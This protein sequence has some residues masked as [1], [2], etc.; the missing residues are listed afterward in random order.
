M[1][2]QGIK[3]LLPG[4]KYTFKT[5]FFWVCMAATI[6]LLNFIPPKRH[7]VL[8][9][10]AVVAWFVQGG[11]WSRIKALFTKLPWALMPGVFFLLMVISLGWSS[12]QQHGIRILEQTAALLV[13]PILLGAQRPNE[14]R[15]WFPTM[16]GMLVINLF[17]FDVWYAI[18]LGNH[19]HEL[20]LSS[21]SPQEP[22]VPMHTSYF[23]IL[24]AFVSLFFLSLPTE[25][26]SKGTQIVAGIFFG[27]FVILV[28]AQ[29][30]LL[31]YLFLLTVGGMRMVVANW[32]RI[33]IWGKIGWI[34][35]PV[36]AIG[37]LLATPTTMSR[38]QRTIDIGIKLPEPGEPQ[39]GLTLRLL[40]W[41]CSV[42]LISEAFWVGHGV[43]DEQ[44]LLN[45][46][47]KER[48]F[49]GHAH[50]FN[51]HNQY[52]Q[53]HLAIGVLGPLFLLIM[54]YGPFL[55][56]RFRKRVE[57][58]FFL[59]LFGICLITETMFYR[60]VG[61][62]FFATFYPLMLW[63]AQLSGIPDPE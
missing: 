19:W 57:T 24:N 6:L 36:L 52:L 18:N 11:L 41:D 21:P 10:L 55:Y 26:L 4:N 30:P 28:G 34:L 44:D 1:I 61:V 27:V 15:D 51:A 46:C 33:T 38:I 2:F 53:A 3:S 60:H 48:N 35:A 37:L 47:Y 8:I 40:K 58:G 42:E 5:A 32:K 62:I 50:N 45:A 49:W 39:T 7:S 59:V 29:S 31:A 20:D 54:L 43:G 56:A 63:Q 22:F 12:N 16:I 13:L 17:V 25:R 14:V 9:I 23:G